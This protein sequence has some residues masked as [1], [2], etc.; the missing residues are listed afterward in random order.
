MNVLIVSSNRFPRG[1]AGALR[2][3]N[4]AKLIAS[5]GMDVEIVA[6]GPS[7]NYQWKTYNDIRY[8]SFR[9]EK[10]DLFSR[11]IGR[12]CYYDN[13]RKLL[14][15]KKYDIFFISS[16]SNY[17]IKQLKKYAQNTKAKLF[18]DC[19]EWYSPEQFRVGQFSRAYTSKNTL[20]TKIID[21]EFKVIA[22]STYLEKYFKNKGINTIRVPVILDVANTRYEKK[23]TEGKIVIMYAGMPGKKDYISDIIAGFARLNQEEKEQ[24]ELRLVGITY[25]DL[26]KKCGVSNQDI[27]KLG[28]VIKC[29][30]RVPHQQVQDLL[31]EADY[32]VLLRKPNQ[33]YAK[34]GFP[35]KFVESLAS[36]TPVICNLS[37]DLAMYIKDGENAIVCSE[38]SPEAMEHSIRKT[39]QI[40][41][42]ERNTMQD[43]ARRTAED[44]FDYRKYAEIFG[45]FLLK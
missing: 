1:D 39:L 3:E 22:I 7:T 6:L 5:E 45:H 34:A 26:E 36:G 16:G 23:T 27:S 4:F 37:S 42:V 29:Y 25:D 20:N 28:T 19:V 32:T 21:K 43:A 13:L 2:E 9:R 17:T 12:L 31:Q 35:T 18:I 24:C 10:T 40:S 15:K 14:N 8:I 38:C 33:R 11:I 44:Y 30:G 41:F